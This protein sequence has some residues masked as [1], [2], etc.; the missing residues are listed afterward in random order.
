[1]LPYKSSFGTGTG[2]ITLQSNRGNFL[3][4]GLN[5]ERGGDKRIRNSEVAYDV[6]YVW[7]LPFMKSAVFSAYR[8][9]AS[10]KD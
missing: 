5:G 4:G 2:F 9:F 10:N 6:A 7:G 8:D 3:L 1:M